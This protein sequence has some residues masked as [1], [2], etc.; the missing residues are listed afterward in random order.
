MKL[1]FIA[2]AMGCAL[3]AQTAG[4]VTTG[5]VDNVTTNSLDWAAAATGDGLSI[6]NNVDF[7]ALTAGPS[8]QGGTYTGSDGVTFS[9]TGAFNS[10]R[11]DAGPGQSNTSGASPGEGVHA[12]SKYLF[13]GANPSS[14]TF[15][16]SADDVFAAGIF[17]LD[18][19]SGS[20]SSLLSVQIE[21][22]SGL[23]GTGVST[24]VF[25]SPA[26]NFQRNGL[27]FMGLVSDTAIKSFIFTD[28]TNNGNDTFGLD[29]FVFA[30]GG[31]AAPIPL[32]GAGLLLLGGVA[33]FAAIGRRKRAS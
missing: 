1:K 21:G 8:L 12:S 3:A 29:D 14:I 5:F 19:F 31:G 10:V 27:Y 26:V 4:A 11:D 33:G 15:N 22:F 23:N 17:T 24:G 18:L 20:S 32:P 28:L 6:N 7:E 16:F 30:T 2:L 9:T 25:S 13:F